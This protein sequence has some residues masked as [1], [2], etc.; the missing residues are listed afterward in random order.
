MGMMDSVNV[1]AELERLY[2]DIAGD[3]EPDHLNILRML[4]KKDHIVYGS[5]FPHSPGRVILMK[6]NH[7]DANPDYDGIREMIYQDNAE[8]M[9]G[10]EV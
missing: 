3:P 1:D 10:R 9:L 2:S 8:K 7:F 4:A 6:K 5:D